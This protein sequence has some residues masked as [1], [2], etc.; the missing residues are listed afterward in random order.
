MRQLA[1]IKVISDIAPIEG[2]DRIV[3]ATVDGWR[4]IVKK[5][6]FRVGDKCVYIEIDSALLNEHL[7]VKRK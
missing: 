2:K 5:D 1:S 3:L 4:V 6:E 7:K